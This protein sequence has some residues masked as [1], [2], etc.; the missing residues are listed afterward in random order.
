MRI[1]KPASGKPGL[2]I[3]ATDT[4]V[5][6]TVAT[7]AIAWALRQHHPHLRVA[8]CKPL[9]SGCRH[10]REGLVSEDAEALAH[11]SDCRQPLDIINPIRFAPPLAPAAAA[12]K[13]GQDVAWSSLETSLRVLGDYGEVL[14]VEG[15]GGLLVPLAPKPHVEGKRQSYETVLDLAVALD[16]PVLVVARADLG[17]LNHTAMTVRLL[18][19]AGCRLAGLVVNGYVADPA[20]TD[21][22]SMAGNRLWLERLTGLK[23]LA[24]LPRCPAAQVQPQKALL[25]P[26]ILEAAA[27]MD[28][29]AVARPPR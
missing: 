1:G 5:G 9:A 13:T 19:E 20:A 29:L 18:R 27:T 7:C 14:L 26:E 6:K 16:Y 11:F 2:F 4:G 10:D 12:E 25:P 21:D 24:T 8:V 22:P 15:V 23:V 3:T 17:T 28:W